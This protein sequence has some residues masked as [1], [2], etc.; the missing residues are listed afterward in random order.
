MFVRSYAHSHEKGEET[1]TNQQQNLDLDGCMDMND[2][3]YASD[4]RPVIPG[5]TC[6]ACNNHEFSRSYIHHLV[7]AKELLAEILLFGHNLHHLIE[8]I[9]AFNNAEDKEKFKD[10]IF[11]QIAG[12]V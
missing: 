7:K 8:L 10:A 2:E 11:I 12:Q 9:R 4:T 5:C 1:S 3:Q 6:L